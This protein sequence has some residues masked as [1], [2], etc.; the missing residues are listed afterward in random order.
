[1]GRAAAGR[2]AAGR[3]RLR[4]AVTPMPAHVNPHEPEVT[5]I[6]I[7][8]TTTHV[9]VAI[10]NSKTCLRRHRRLFEQLLAIVRREDG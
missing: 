3:G 4:A 10:E 9:T 5:A 8:D 2:D 1:V 7:S 6:I